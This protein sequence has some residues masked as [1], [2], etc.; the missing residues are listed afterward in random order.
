[1][2]GHPW[3]GHGAG[4]VISKNDCV[5]QSF[6]KECDYVTTARTRR[7]YESA[8]H[9]SISMCQAVRARGRRRN[10][11]GFRPNTKDLVLELDIAKDA[12]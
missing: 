4:D 11:L 5:L 1:M 7:V 2:T 8:R 9:T 10:V 12:S 6:P 3:C